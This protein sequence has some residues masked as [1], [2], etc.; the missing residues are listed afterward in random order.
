MWTAFTSTNTESNPT[1]IKII[2]LNNM[3]K[4]DIAT[5]NNT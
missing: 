5:E 3:K 4:S 2:F 1:N